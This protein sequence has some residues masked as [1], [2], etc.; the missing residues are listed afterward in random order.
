VEEGMSSEDV[1][2]IG[3]TDADGGKEVH[4]SEDEVRCVHW[5]EAGGLWWV[6]W[7][8]DTAGVTQTGCEVIAGGVAVGQL[9]FKF[10]GVALRLGKVKDCKLGPMLWQWRGMLMLESHLAWP[11]RLAL[12]VGD[13]C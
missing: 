8:G 7:W 13:V 4:H 12:V 10:V 11:R 9:C 6:R 2:G 3:K 1:S 5:E